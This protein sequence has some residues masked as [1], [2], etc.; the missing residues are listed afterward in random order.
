MEY[1][2]LVMGKIIYIGILFLSFSIKAQNKVIEIKKTD[3]IKI[4]K[5]NNN[6]YLLTIYFRKNILFN[7]KNNF[8]TKVYAGGFSSCEK[9]KKEFSFYFVELVPKPKNYTIYSLNQYI[10]IDKNKTEYFK[11]QEF[12]NNYFKIKGKYYQ[13][14]RMGPIP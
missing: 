1:K 6:S 8:K 12:W 10:S 13:L 5:E 11:Y 7:K 14:K 4:I 9:C 3:T 2:L